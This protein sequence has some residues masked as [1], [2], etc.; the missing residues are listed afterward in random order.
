[1]P[2]ARFFEIIFLDLP[3]FKRLT[4]VPCPLRKQAKCL[5]EALPKDCEQPEVFRLALH[6]LNSH[7]SLKAHRLAGLLP[8]F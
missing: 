7:L 6:A 1:M 4:E 3:V 2:R 5:S 8:V